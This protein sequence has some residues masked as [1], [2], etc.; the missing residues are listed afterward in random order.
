MSQNDKDILYF[1]AFCLESFKNKHGIGGEEASDLFDKFGI[2]QY[3]VKN[4]DI[5][6]TQGM[7]WIL[8]EIEE[9]MGL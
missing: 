8:E 4:Y 7:P 6:H 9:M 5:L 1:V 2:K 3:L